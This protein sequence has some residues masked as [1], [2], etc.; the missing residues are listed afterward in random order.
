MGHMRDEDTHVAELRAQVADDRLGRLGRATRRVQ[1]EIER[2]A[3]KP[4]DHFLE[5]LDVF[6][7]DAQQLGLDAA[8]LRPLRRIQDD[9]PARLLSECSQV[10]LANDVEGGRARG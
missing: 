3:R 10:L 9:G 8:R 5:A 1:D 2:R 6:R 7:G 4:L